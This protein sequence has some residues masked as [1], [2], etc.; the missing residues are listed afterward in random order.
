M[1]SNITKP[2]VISANE[3]QV[4]TPQTEQ[5]FAAYHQVRFNEL[6][7]PWHQAKGSEV[8]ALEAQAVHRMVCDQQGNVLAVGRLHKVSK[9]NAQI[10]FM[11]VNSAHQGKGL[12]YMVLQALELEAAKQGVLQIQLNAREVAL[13]FYKKCGYNLI[14]QVHTLYDEVKHYAMNKVLN[15][16]PGNCTQ[17]LSE[18]KQSW[19]NTIP[20]AKAMQLHPSFY[21]REQLFVIADRAANINLHNTM[22]AGSIYTLATL[23]GWGWVQLLLKQN[24][25]S[26]DIVLA[27]GNIRYIKPLQGEPLAKTSTELVSGKIAAIARGRKVRVNVQVNV[28]DGDNIVA[29]FHGKYVAIPDQ[30]N[31]ADNDNA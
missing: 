10:R 8:D 19:H 6:R 1:N 16:S 2:N 13:A 4:C 12:G 15:E 18:L 3:Y 27:D 24:N 31:K 9:T 22:F 29:E 26:A 14:E 17:W 11:A 5:E 25:L 7:K 28:H 20:M 23:T 30:T 21:D